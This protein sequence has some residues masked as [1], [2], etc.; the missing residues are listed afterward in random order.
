MDLHQQF[1]TSLFFILS[2]LV[3]KLS[4]W[5][6]AELYFQYFR[7]YEFFCLFSV[8]LMSMSASTFKVVGSG[9]FLSGGAIQMK[10]GFDQ[11]CAFLLDGFV[12]YGWFDTSQIEHLPP[13]RI[14]YLAHFNS[15]LKMYSVQMYC[16]L[17]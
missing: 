13:L 8:F 16:N 1:G 17:Q 3:S 12:F 11:K 7:K 14:K 10:N 5:F 4:S 9:E 2:L 6:E 15:R